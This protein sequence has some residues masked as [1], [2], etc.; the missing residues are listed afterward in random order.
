[1]KE[2]FPDYDGGLDLKRAREFL[3]N[4]Y[5]SLNHNEGKNIYNHIT[6]ATDTKKHKGRIKRRNRHCCQSVVP[7]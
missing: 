5:L 3:T 7:N 1:M 6:T 2:A 4:K